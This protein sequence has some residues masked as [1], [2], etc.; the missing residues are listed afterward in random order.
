MN[1]SVRASRVL[2]VLEAYR[3]LTAGQW[4]ANAPAL[5]SFSDGEQLIG[6]YSNDWEKNSELVLFTTKSICVLFND[7]KWY[8]IKFEDIERTIA[9]NGKENVKGFS[10]LL[11]DQSR[12]WLP[13]GG[14]RAGRFFDAFE[15]LRFVDR[16]LADAQNEPT[17][18]HAKGVRPSV[19]ENKFKIA[20]GLFL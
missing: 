15:V 11:R 9:P 18:N 10:L 12:I 19:F 14:S 6:A 8:V 1:V 7:R 2:G 13:I 16:V 3:D 17:G 20:E 5:P 4:S